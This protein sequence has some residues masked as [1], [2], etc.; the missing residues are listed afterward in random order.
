MNLPFLGVGMQSS[1]LQYVPN[2]FA[3]AALDLDF[4]LGGSLNSKVTYTRANDATVVTSSGYIDDAFA[5]VPRLDYDP[6][7][8]NCK[9]LLIEK[10]SSNMLLYSEQFS[11][12][13]WAVNNCLPNLGNQTASPFSAIKA[14]VV[15]SSAAGA[16]YTSQ[17]IVAG[18]SSYTF[19]VFVKQNTSTTVKLEIYNVTTAASLATKSANISEG[20]PFINGWYRHSV[21]VSSGITFG[22]TISFRIYPD[23]SNTGAGTSI[24]VF[25]ASAEPLTS[26]PTSYIRTL[27]SARA[28]SADSAIINGTNFSSWFSATSGTFYAEAQVATATPPNYSFMLEGSIPGGS[29]WATVT[30]A[31]GNSSTSAH[32][33]VR[34]STGGANITE[35]WPTTYSANQII[36]GAAAYDTVGLSSGLAW[37]GAT[38]SPV[39]TADQ[40]IATQLNIGSRTGTVNFF[41]GHIRR[42][43]FWSSRLTNAQLQTITT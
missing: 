12:P 30:I 13:N 17:N 26:V 16:A 1:I 24:Y 33:G 11:K 3:S 36:K 32:I 31:T 7:L 10:A 28:R 15:T 25:G 2:L 9:G 6:V 21:S 27:T 8:K 14:D 40:F 4:T 18:E 23:N 37:N 35:S 19:S 34:M 41:N 43:S 20:T 22:N 39:N 29:D 5:D 38:V 42:V